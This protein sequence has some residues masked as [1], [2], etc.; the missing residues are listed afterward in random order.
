MDPYP[1]YYFTGDGGYIDNDGYVFVMG[2][3]DDVINVSGHR[4][5]T[6]GMEEVVANHPDVAECAVLGVNDSLKGEVPIGFLVLK[7]GAQ[8]QPDEI[9]SDVVQSVRAEIG[10][11]ACFKKA[12]VV[13]RL[14]KTRSGKILRGTIRKIANG[15]EYKMPSTIDDPAVLGEMETAVKTIGYGK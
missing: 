12:A 3:V 1:G 6:G 8:K 7:A 5:S 13:D 4:L 10:P 14:P 11:I 2:R 9:V 15:E